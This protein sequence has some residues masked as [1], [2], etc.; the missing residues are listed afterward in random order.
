VLRAGVP[1]WINEPPNRS[2]VL[3]FTPAQPK[4]GGGGAFYLLLRRRR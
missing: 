4:D 2:R 3:A 1:R